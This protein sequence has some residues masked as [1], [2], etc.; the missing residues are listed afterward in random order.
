MH[1]ESQAG[2]LRYLSDTSITELYPRRDTD[3]IAELNS[4][5]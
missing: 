4:G 5:D 3:H 2:D 1:D